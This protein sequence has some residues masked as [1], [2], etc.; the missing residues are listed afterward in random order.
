MS[1][2]WSGLAVAA[3]LAVI[4]ASASASSWTLQSTPTP[5]G[6]TDGW[7]YSVSCPSANDCS[8]VGNYQDSTGAYPLAEQWDGTSWTI[9]PMP[10]PSGSVGTYPSA[11]SCASAS[12]CTA[13]GYYFDSAGRWLLLAERWDGTSWTVQSI[14][15]PSGP[16]DYLN[17]VSCASASDC[18]AVGVHNT[19]TLT[20]HWDGTSWTA[21]PS[22]SPSGQSSELRGV[23]CA[24]ASDCTAVGALYPPNAVQVGRIGV[25]VPPDGTLAEHWDGSSWTI[26]QTPTS[27]VSSTFT[28]ASCISASACTAVGYYG[29]GALAERWNG[30]AWM[31]QATPDTSGEFYGVSCAAASACTAVGS[32]STA[33]SQAVPMAEGWD[34]LTWVSEPI[35][36]PPGSTLA[37]LYGVSCTS[38]SVCT[39]VGS[40][41]SGSRSGGAFIERY[42]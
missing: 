4:P 11:V 15:T 16:Y 9:V 22:P 10:Q 24:S 8:A 41:S 21:E 29:E 37:L 38:A 32:D 19:S 40:Y 33:G 25:A 5:A 7:L 18:M 20:E 35:P 1:R 13:V 12:A 27:L 42:S 28:G 26:E 3:V 39:A 31:I 17:G 30:A 34:G 23:S 36:N 14:P 6:A 2:W